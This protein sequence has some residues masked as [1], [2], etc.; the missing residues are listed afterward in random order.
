MSAQL[1]YATDCRCSESLEILA[2]K[3]NN[4]A[5][6]FPKCQVSGVS[7]GFSASLLP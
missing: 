1:F 3:G 6:T 4:K 7:G 2:G 5:V